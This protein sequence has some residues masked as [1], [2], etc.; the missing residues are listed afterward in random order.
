MLYIIKT[1]SLTISANLLCKN[2][3]IIKN[4]LFQKNLKTFLKIVV[5]T[6]FSGFDGA[7]PKTLKLVFAN[8]HNIFVYQQ[9]QN[10]KKKLFSA[11][12]SYN[13]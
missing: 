1:H 10:P 8:R 6:S 9:Q 5:K 11:I 2:L 12:V 13:F 3:Q 7:P 4:Y